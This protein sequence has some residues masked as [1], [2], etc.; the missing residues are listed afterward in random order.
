MTLQCHNGVHS[1]AWQHVKTRTHSLV[2]SF[3]LSLVVLLYAIAPRPFFLLIRGD[4]EPGCTATERFSAKFPRAHCVSRPWYWSDNTKASASRWLPWAGRTQD[5]G[6]YPQIKSL[7]YQSRSGPNPN[8]K[9]KSSF[10]PKIWKLVR[11]VTFCDI[12]KCHNVTLLKF[13]TFLEFCHTVCNF[14]SFLANSKCRKNVEISRMS[15]IRIL[16][17]SLFRRSANIFVSKL[18]FAVVWLG[19][20]QNLDTGHVYVLGLKSGSERLSE[21]LRSG[22]PDVNINRFVPV[23][24]NLLPICVICDGHKLSQIRICDRVCFSVFSFW[25]EVQRG[26]GRK[27]T[28]KNCGRYLVPDWPR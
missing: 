22:F 4:S 25:P 27:H 28:L 26:D 7:A 12:S 16:Y 3:S 8:T 13:V 14:F 9:D 5:N 15:Q 21:S 6:N 17:R 2:F 10:V 23:K 20:I 19:Q 1:C 24:L 18:R 11:N